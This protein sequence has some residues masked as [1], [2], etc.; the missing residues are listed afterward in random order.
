MDLD[1]T[2][3]AWQQESIPGRRGNRAKEN[4]IALTERQ[5]LQADLARAVAR[6]E[7]QEHQARSL[8]ELSQSLS[9][10]LDLDDLRQTI[11]ESLY[12]TLHADTTSLFIVDED[13]SLRMVAQRNIDLTRARIVFGAE[14]G[15]VALAVHQH[16]PVYVPDTSRNARYISTGHDHPR[17]MLA[18]PIEPQSGS[19]Y[20]AC[21]VRRRIFAFTD[22]E[23]HFA[24]LMGSVAAHALS[25]TGLY[26]QMSNLAREQA[27]LF[28]LAR[29]SGISDS[30]GTFLNQIAE[31]VCHALGAT[32]CIIMLVGDT[33]P[34]AQP[35]GR[36][37][38]GA[39]TSEALV[40]C[41]AFAQELAI[42]QDSNQVAIRCEVS[43]AG[44]QLVMAPVVAHGHFIA[45]LGWEILVGGDA[46][47]LRKNESP[48][49][50]E[51]PQ[52]LIPEA[53]M[54]VGMLSE[55]TATHIP[56]SEQQATFIA[57]L[58][59]QVALGIENLQLRMRDLGA[60]RSLSA[61][62]M[63]RAHLTDLRRAIVNEISNVFFPSRVALILQEESSG[64][65]HLAAASHNSEASWIQTALHLTTQA[66]DR[67]IFQQ[68]GIAIAA[69]I[70]N[71]E[72]L[73]WLA[74][75]LAPLPRLTSDRALLL[76][77]L[78]STASLILHNARLHIMANEA[79]V[80]RERHR[81]A[82]EIHDGVAQ[83]LAHLM[84]RL[85]LVQRLVDGDPERAKIEAGGA[86]N[87]LLTSLND[88]RQSIAALAP[89]QL[90]ELGFSG[91]VES[92]LDDILTNTP[93]LQVEFA[94]CPDS[95]IPPE[96]R[97]PAFRVVQEA[98]ANIRKHSN[99]ANAWITVAIANERLS[100]TV[101]D[102]G[103]GFDADLAAIPS[104]HFGLRG[105]RDRAEEFGG[106]LS[107][108]SA[109]GSGT[110]VE[111]Q[112]PLALAA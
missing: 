48:S 28:E 7:Q 3:D 32:G 4:T 70:S 29:A 91:A 30:I 79:A 15:L 45:M 58:C 100:V 89:A 105:M 10:A 72:T 41:A 82:R 84:L 77:S 109:P 44:S 103:Q 75:K 68:R 5:Q 8:F 98:L 11:I 99:A 59:Q 111:L 22:D 52:H 107:I 87:V 14:E 24:N 95:Q 33:G 18:V 64:E 85:E 35:R 104:G 16:R 20:V 9:V 97:A 37:T 96:L 112:L 81:I 83:N 88:L 38:S 63:S 17:S 55:M 6:A 47:G 74:I 27:T 1:L 21:I 92:L 78:A 31:P 69:L 49:I 12:E 67:E 19:C 36:A 39:V 61:L 94:S 108:H 23:L 101:R 13:N 56:I 54:P 40:Q 110:S 71:D 53:E 43:P 25:N 46:H 57:N 26:S 51:I 2:E 50:W 80:D 93:S 73:G 102:D 76:T 60:L 34:S 90:E 65:P 42:L 86:R 106:S 66:K 62:P